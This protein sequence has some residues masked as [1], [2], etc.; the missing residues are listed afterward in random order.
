MKIID[1]IIRSYCFIAKGKGIRNLDNAIMAANVLF[2]AN[3]YAIYNYVIGTIV[4]ITKI[5]IF[6]NKS[7]MLFSIVYALSGCIMY[8]CSLKFLN[9]IYLNKNKYTLISRIQIHRYIGITIVILHYLISIFAF[10]YSGRFLPH[11]PLLE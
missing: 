7:L 4:S 9:R 11:L 1:V 3:E 2:L 10:F 6:P 5:D 8:Y